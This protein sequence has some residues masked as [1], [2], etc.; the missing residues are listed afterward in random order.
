MTVH[1]EFITSQIVNF[2]CKGM[3]EELLSFRLS[4]PLSLKDIVF[5]TI[6]TFYLFILFIVGLLY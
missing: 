5:Q 4:Q 2:T 6:E 3:E 1:Q